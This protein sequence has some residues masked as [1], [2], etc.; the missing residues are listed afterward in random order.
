MMAYAL[1]DTTNCAV[2]L[3]LYEEKGPLV[4][5]LLPCTHSV[6]VTCLQR[7]FK[8]DNSVDCPVCGDHQVSEK[9]IDGIYENRYILKNIRKPQP[10]CEKH[11]REFILFCNENGCKRVICSICMKDDHKNHNFKDL[12]DAA[13]ESREVLVNNVEK[14]KKE[15][16]ASR[17][18]LL[19]IR[20]RN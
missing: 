2:C 16:Q 17:E 15:A 19:K 14:V 13:T 10:R 3:E 8:K 12:E 20:E 7:I 4:P 6:C 11:N 18:M 1:D 5:K 9:G